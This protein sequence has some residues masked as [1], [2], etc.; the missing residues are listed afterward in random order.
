MTFRT[1]KE[2]LSGTDASEEMCA[3]IFR[4]QGVNRGDFIDTALS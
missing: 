3:L 2:A 1:S 4:G